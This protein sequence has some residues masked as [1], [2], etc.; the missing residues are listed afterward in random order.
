VTSVLYDV[1]GP[2]ARRRSLLG[3]I[4]GGALI[5]ALLAV[6]VMRLNDRGVL[7]ADRWRI[8]TDP[9]RGDASDVWRSLL[10]EGLGATL[11]AA[12]LAAVLALVLGVILVILRTSASRVVRLPAIG[13]IELFRGIPVVLLMF[14]GVIALG[15]PI[16]YG[17]VF[18]LVIYNAAII[19]EILRAGIVSLPTGQAEAAHAL[20]LTNSQ[21]LFTILLPQAIRRMLPSLVSQFV[22]LLKDTSLGFIIGYTE[23]LR[24]I[25]LNAE[26]FGNRFWFPLFF[27]GAGIYILINFSLSR[28]AVWLERRGTMKAAGG[29]AKADQAQIAGTPGTGIGPGGGFGAP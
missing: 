15:L 23:L 11:R 18:G 25:R 10:L 27:V 4:V 13:I 20:G 28:L 5:A 19:G 21:T 12:A 14:F 7:D 8:F 3:S 24:V 17:V 2:T 29:V 6:I 16:F 1:P 9:R 26:F 22:V